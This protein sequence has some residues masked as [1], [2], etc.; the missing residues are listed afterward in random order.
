MVLGSEEGHLFHG[1]LQVD[2]DSGMVNVVESFKVVLQTPEYSSILEI[3]LVHAFK[4]PSDHRLLT[5][6]SCR[7]F[8]ILEILWIQTADFFR[9]DRQFQELNG[10]LKEFKLVLNH[11]SLKSRK[12][13]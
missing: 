6:K 2:P 11:V 1:V 13:E 10:C 4:Q 8:K 9:F 5:M 3:K 7:I 12:I